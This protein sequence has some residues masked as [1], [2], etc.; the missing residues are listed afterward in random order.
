[1][2]I[3]TGR[4]TVLKPQLWMMRAETLHQMRLDKDFANP[5]GAG[6]GE[7]LSC[8]QLTGTRE[9]GGATQIYNI[10]SAA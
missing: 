8:R 5:R 2:V 3:M 10:K 6:Q 9:K 1:M 4:A 7:G